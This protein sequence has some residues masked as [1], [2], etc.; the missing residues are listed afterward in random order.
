[1]W[2][3]NAIVTEAVDHVLVH[4]GCVAGAFEGAVLLPGRS[5]AG[6]STLTA[7]CVGEGLHYL[8]DEL[9]GLHLDHGVVSP[10][11]RPIGLDH[12]HLIV[13]SGLGRVLQR[14][15]APA[16][17]VFPRYEPGATLRAVPLDAGW[18]LVALAAHSPNLAALGPRGLAALGGLAL[19]CPAVQVT[20]G[21]AAEAVS[22]VRD[23]AARRGSRITAPPVIDSLIPGLTAIA[24]GEELGVLHGASG[25]VSLL[26]P[27]AAAIWQHVAGSGSSRT[28]IESL[29]R[30]DDGPALSRSVIEATIGR[31][32]HDGLLPPA[33]PATVATT[34]TGDPAGPPLQEP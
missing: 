26:N 11:A 7:A 25:R 6:K 21:D 23:L 13:A 2:H 20:Y 19:A 3:L 29:I 9:A 8:S 28:E 10:Y 31:L 12:E 24:L 4:A 16:A 18:A 15:A 22:V 14:P 27:A 33:N 32:R 17:V 30:G 34:T 5:G 1:V